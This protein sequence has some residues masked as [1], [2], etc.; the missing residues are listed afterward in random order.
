[1][2]TARKCPCASGIRQNLP[3]SAAKPLLRSHWALPLPSFAATRLRL[4]AST[5]I[6]ATALPPR[7]DSTSPCIRSS[8]GCRL[9][10]NEL[11]REAAAV[12]DLKQSLCQRVRAGV[13]AERFEPIGEFG[14]IRRDQ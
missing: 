1:M 5:P 14:K 12:L 8:P 3:G 2:S 10:F 9:R 13:D 4:P 7:A 11:N 6:T